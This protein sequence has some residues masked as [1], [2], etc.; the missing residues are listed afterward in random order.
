MKK[1]LEE[2]AARVPVA[3]RRG[4]DVL[5]EVVVLRSVD[6]LHPGVVKLLRVCIRTTQ[7]QYQR[8]KITTMPLIV[9][10]MFLSVS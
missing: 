7:R 4:D 2:A 1:W 3:E 8:R 10:R 6:S 5:D 9:C